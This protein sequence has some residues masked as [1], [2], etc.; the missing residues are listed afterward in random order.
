MKITIKTLK[1]EAF[2]V[3]VD[4]EKDTVRT[5][6]EKFFQESKQDYPVE[7]QRLIYLGKIMED[8][9]PLSQYDLDN[10][11]FVVVMNKK[12]TAAAPAADT[13]TSSSASN[14]PA[15]SAAATAVKNETTAAAA[16]TPAAATE[17]PKEE[18][19]PKEDITDE[20]PQ[21]DDIQIKIQRIKEMGYSE[22][23]ARIA[24]EICDNNPDRA[25]EYLLSEI[26]T[27]S[28]GSGGGGGGGGTLP[29]SASQESR[30]AFL[31]EHP[32]FAD[33]KHL[34]Q[35]DPSLLPHLLQK[36]QSTNPDLMRIISENQV[37]FLALINEGT[38]GPE[39]RSG[40]HREL[41]TTAAAM[42][43]SLTPTDMDAIDRL[44]ALGYPEHLVIQA[45]IAC[46]RNEYQAAEFLVS[47][48]L[49]DDD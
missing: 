40:V 11:K 15:A 2:H 22:E 42:V 34:L 48:N 35:D 8:E 44:K 39:G 13:A 27:S 4:V 29:S 36:I 19:K 26:A 16:A 31:R 46:E 32:V 24:L 20:E 1:Q 33:M 25:V 47:Q 12:P 18:E 17:K 7:R 3:E 45:Y 14:A 10:K 21:Q 43:D 5:L 9:H 28:M 41:E 23:E 38:D 30:L 6:K 37:E 49:D